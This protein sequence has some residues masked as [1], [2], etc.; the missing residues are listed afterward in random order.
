MDATIENEWH[1]Y[2]QFTPENGPL[3]TVFDYK[4]AKGNFDLVGKTKEGAYKKVYNDI[5]EIDEYFFSDKAHFVQ[6]I[7]VIN[8]K[9]KEIKVTLAGQ[10]C[11]EGKCIG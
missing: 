2:S 8:P 10:V 7:K 3:P 4:N 1:M 9:L 11:I 6:L 5:F